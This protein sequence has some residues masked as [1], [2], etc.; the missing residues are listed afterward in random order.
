MEKVLKYKS[1]QPCEHPGCW[2]HMSY[3]CET[4][5]RIACN[6]DV[7]EE[8]H[9]TIHEF[10]RSPSRN[11]NWWIVYGFIQQDLIWIRIHWLQWGIKVSKKPPLFSERMGFKK[12]IT[13]HGWRIG[14]LK[15]KGY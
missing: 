6:G 2:A 7:F 9:V 8:G 12:T 1:G 15:A 10:D 13:V 4:C 14:W 11:F 5:G 3:P